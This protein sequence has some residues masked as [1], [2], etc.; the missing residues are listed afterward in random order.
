M[1]LLGFSGVQVS[2]SFESV[3]VKNYKKESIGG[4]VQSK[5]V[6]EAGYRHCR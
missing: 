3:K 1:L 6:V 5:K 2:P 4:F